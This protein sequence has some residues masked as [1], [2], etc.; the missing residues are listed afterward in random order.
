MTLSTIF[1]GPAIDWLLPSDE[2]PFHNPVRE[3]LPTN[4]PE[5][6]GATGLVLTGYR[7]FRLN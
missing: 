7:G 1:D 4:R 5:S 2:Q 6:S 3:G